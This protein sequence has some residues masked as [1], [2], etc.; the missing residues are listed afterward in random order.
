MSNTVQTV[1]GAAS[2]GDLGRVLPHEHIASVYGG[3]GELLPEPNAEWEQVV[4]EHYM[5][6]LTCLVQDHD[7]RTLVEVSPSWGGRGKRDLEVWA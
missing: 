4:L 7:F 3:W 2:V 6:L 5:P 1:L